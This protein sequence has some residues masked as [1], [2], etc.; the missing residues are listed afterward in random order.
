MNDSGFPKFMKVLFAALALYTGIEHK[1]YISQE[2]NLRKA[3]KKI[4]K[5]KNDSIQ[6]RKDSI[7]RRNDSISHANRVRDNTERFLKEEEEQ[8]KNLYFEPIKDHLNR[9]A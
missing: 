7:R 9:W 8:Y 2:I 5:K 4:E 3:E 6:C 1:D